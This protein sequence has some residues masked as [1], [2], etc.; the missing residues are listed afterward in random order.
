MPS[1][2]ALALQPGAV[3]FHLQFEQRGQGLG[4]GL[5]AAG[6]GGVKPALQRPGES[7]RGDGLPLVEHR[8]RQGRAQ[9]QRTGQGG[10]GAGDAR[11]L[12]GQRRQTDAAGLVHRLVHGA[13]HGVHQRLVRFNV[14]AVR[15]C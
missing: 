14:R 4:Q 1:P 13:A 12:V 2:P 8:H 11:H 15:G 9:A 6:K 7:Q 5:H 10:V 3:Q